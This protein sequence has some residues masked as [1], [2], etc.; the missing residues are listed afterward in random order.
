[1]MLDFSE[2]FRLKTSNHN[3]PDKL[4]SIHCESHDAFMVK[5]LQSTV[6]TKIVLTCDLNVT[7]TSTKYFPSESGL[8]GLYGPHSRETLLE[9]SFGLF[10]HN[11]KC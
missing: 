8:K 10:P 11:V 2:Q 3:S 7:T 4:S 1:M 6:E 9:H 5:H